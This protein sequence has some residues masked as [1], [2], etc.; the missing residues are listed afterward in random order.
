M[1]TDFKVGMR[2]GIISGLWG[3]CTFTIV[4]WIF[5]AFRQDLPATR[6]RAYGGLFSI[7]I[8]ITGLYFGMRAVKRSNENQISYGLAIKTGVVISV[9]TGIIVAIFTYLYCAVINPGYQEFMVK[10]TENVLL[11]TKVSSAEINRQLV[12]T[13]KE[14]STSMQVVQALVGQMVTGSIASLIIGLF[15]RTKK[16]K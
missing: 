1:K 3:L 10:E 4:G 11:A 2:T 12:A 8:L 9:L 5:H 7:I 13:S 6:I 15:I 14:F 16:S